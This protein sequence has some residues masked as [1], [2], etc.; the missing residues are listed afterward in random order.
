METLRLRSKERVDIIPGDEKQI[1]LHEFDSV[2]FE[3]DALAFVLNYEE[4]EMT[5]MDFTAFFTKIKNLGRKTIS[6]YEGDV[7]ADVEIYPHEA[8]VEG[9]A[10]ESAFAANE[11]GRIDCPLCDKN[12]SN[13]S[14][15][16]KHMEKVHGTIV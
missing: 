6:I 1:R 4:A 7:V 12:Y 11:D 10:V 15:L 5:F 13:E 3:N 9:I 16:Q 2:V 8:V 14:W